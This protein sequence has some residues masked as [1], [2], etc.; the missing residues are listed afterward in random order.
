[1][2]IGL[3]FRYKDLS[4]SLGEAREER[5]QK[6]VVPDPS[7]CLLHGSYRNKPWERK[8]LSRSH[9]GVESRRPLGSLMPL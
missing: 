4:C 9:K 3:L 6:C 5:V 1:M 2:R 8:T 7:I